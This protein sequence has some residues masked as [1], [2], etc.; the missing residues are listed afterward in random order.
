MR[1]EAA[2]MDTTVLAASPFQGEKMPGPVL[3]LDPCSNV[4]TDYA[5]LGAMDC[6]LADAV[7]S[8]DGDVQIVYN[9]LR[10][11]VM[12]EPHFPG[13]NLLNN[14]QT[15]GAQLATAN[16]NILTAIDK[17]NAL[18]IQVENL[19]TDVTAIKAQVVPSS[20]PDLLTQLA[21]LASNVLS[22]I[23]GISFSFEKVDGSSLA[24]DLGAA[25]QALLTD[26]P[27]SL[28]SLDGPHTVVS[29]SQMEWPVGSYYL[30]I[31][32]SPPASWGEI[33][34]NP[35]KYI[36]AVGYYTWL[37]DNGASTNP[38]PIETFNLDLKRPSLN[39]SDVIIWLHDGVAA[40]YWWVKLF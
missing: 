6:W 34:S 4:P 8:T 17:I 20:A 10:T 13:A 31:Q 11:A 35:V 25:L 39:T 32:T 21:T 26:P 28:L 22:I 36:P 29:G 12:D 9:Y 33:A 15:F 7:G 1:L 3:P 30:K 19:Q 37:L 5:D 18:A 27:E 23:T 38:N 2:R 24:Y 40:D 16:T 14:V